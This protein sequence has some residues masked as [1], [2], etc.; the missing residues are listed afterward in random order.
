MWFKFAITAYHMWSLEYDDSDV[1]FPMETTNESEL[2]LGWPYLGFSGV[3]DL[4][5][6]STALTFVNDDSDSNFYPLS[7]K[8]RTSWSNFEEMPHVKVCLI[9]LVTL[10]DSYLWVTLLVLG[11][12]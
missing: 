4:G 5:S 1:G 11:D 6:S 2:G 8:M 7:K 10:L 9:L 12:M 3:F